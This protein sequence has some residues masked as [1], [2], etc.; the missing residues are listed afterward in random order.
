MLA[1]LTAAFKEEEQQKKRQ[2][3]D[4]LFSF[5]TI[6]RAKQQTYP[7]YPPKNNAGSNN[8]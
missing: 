5:T 4:P 3:T 6:P 7:W 2:Q 8:H 1:F